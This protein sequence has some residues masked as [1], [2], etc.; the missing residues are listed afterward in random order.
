MSSTKYPPNNNN[1]S[2]TDMDLLDDSD[3]S[4]TNNNN[5]STTNS[6]NNNN[7]TTTP[8]AKRKRIDRTIKLEAELKTLEAENR[9]LKL[10]LKLGKELVPFMDANEMELHIKNLSAALASN[11]EEQINLALKAYSAKFFDFGME[12]NEAM[13]RHIQ[14]F[15]R[16]LSPMA[17]TKVCMYCLCQDEEFF[18][19]TN[20]NSLWNV[21]VKEIS[22]TAEQ[23]DEFKRFRDN[24]RVLT[25]GLRIAQMEMSGLKE[26]V[27]RK[28]KALTEEIREIQSILSPKQFVKLILWCSQNPASVA[29]LNTV[30]DN[31]LQQA[32]NSNHTTTTS[33]NNNNNSSSPQ[34]SAINNNNNTSASSSYVSNNNNNMSSNTNSSNN[35]S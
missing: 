8:S 17:I 9:E 22:C 1:N 30:W 3:D 15:D 21:L 27:I 7:S 11:S 29:M 2:N 34:R 5:P 28:N 19:S 6:S 35:D 31:S 14:Q 32:S 18:N 25:R 10:R 12:R 4:H 13:S 33:S 20:Q 24:A 23:I 26:R 16:L